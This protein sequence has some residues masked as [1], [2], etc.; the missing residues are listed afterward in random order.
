M[1]H[2]DRAWAAA[3]WSGD[4]AGAGGG[5]NAAAWLVPGADTVRVFGRAEPHCPVGRDLT[6]AGTSWPRRAAANTHLHLIYDTADEAFSFRTVR[7][8][9]T[10]ASGCGNKCWTSVQATQRFDRHQVLGLLLNL[11]A[12]SANANTV[13]LFHDGVRVSQPIPLPEVLK[14]KTLFPAVT[15]RN[16][17]L[18][19]NFGPVPMMPLPFKCHMLGAAATQD[20]EVAAPTQ[21][22]DGKFE[23]VFPILLP[24]E[25]SFDWVDLFLQQHPDFT[26][27]SD[28]MVLEWCEKS[29]IPRNHGYAWRTSND[30]PDMQMN[31]PELDGLCIQHVLRSIASAHRRN[32]LVVELKSSLLPGERKVNVEFE[33]QKEVQRAAKKALPAE[34]ERRA[35]AGEVL[36]PSSPTIQFSDDYLFIRKFYLVVGVSTYR[37][38][39][40]HSSGKFLFERVHTDEWANSLDEMAD[41]EATQPGAAPDMQVEEEDEVIGSPTELAEDSELDDAVGGIGEVEGVNPPGKVKVEKK[42]RR[43]ARGLGSANGGRLP[44][45]PDDSDEEEEDSPS[46]RALRSDD[47]PLSSR[48]IRDLLTGHLAEMKTAWGSF[49]GRLDKVE[50]EQAKTTF[51]VSNL[52]SRLRV[53]EKDVAHQKQTTTTHG[54]ALDNLTAEV[55]N[56]KVKIDALDSKFA[57]APAPTG[58]VPDASAARSDPWAAYLNQRATNTMPAD[59]KDPGPSGDVDRGDVLSAEDMRT[60][61]VGGWLQDTKRSVI[62]EESAVILGI[63]EIKNFIDSDKLM[64]YGP[65][66]SVG[67]LR[68]VTREG[69]EFK[70]TKNRMWEVIKVLGRLKH[71]LPSTRSSGEE[72]T[73]WASFVKTKNA[74]AKSSHVSLTRRVAMMLAKDHETNPGVNSVVGAYDCDWNMGTIWNGAEK[75]GSATHR[76]PKCEDEFILL[77]GGWVNVSAVARVAGCATD[78]AKSAFEREL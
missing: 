28:R 27:L 32:F 63:P 4:L 44:P 17:T 53:A 77:S 46:K 48:E 74:R 29:G 75:L 7:A 61:V 52:Q 56:M 22:K 72:K 18:A 47:L 5:I 58:G 21:P 11:D 57:S 13:S 19:F 49:Q 2:Y 14:G 50:G 60:L 16:I 76:Q 20:V 69:E 10:V 66:R 71:V 8:A 78:E 59:R 31:V 15:F 24:D 3:V 40:L 45:V 26:E 30:K 9:L 39:S 37:G 6:R 54:A 34:V 55:K 36:D 68:F 51:E 12:N 70:D 25:G 67:L 35:A 73:L 42:R 62:E 41:D 33:Q 38:V 1:E 65:R 64:I 43:G 23:V